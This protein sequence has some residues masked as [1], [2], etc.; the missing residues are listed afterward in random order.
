M[1][2][3]FKF[4]QVNVLDL[5]YNTSLTID[6]FNSLA[7]SSIKLAVRVLKLDGLKNMT[8]L[9]LAKILKESKDSLEY[10]SLDNVKF[11]R[12]L[13]TNLK[14]VWDNEHFK[15]MNNCRNLVYISMTSLDGITEDVF[16][17]CSNNCKIFSLHSEFIDA[18]SYLT[19]VQQMYHP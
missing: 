5:S 4:K 18:H 13:R 15:H 16:S 17:L 10:L 1:Q 9:L 6:F 7:E 8:S 2:E 3:L 14:T 12:I 19:R 11:V